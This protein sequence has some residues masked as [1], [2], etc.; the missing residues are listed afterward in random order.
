MGHVW[1]RPN[2][3]N[4]KSHPNYFKDSQRGHS[5]TLKRVKVLES[6]HPSNN[7]WSNP[8]F[9]QS[10]VHSTTQKISNQI[11]SNPIDES[12]GHTTCHNSPC[13]IFCFFGRCLSLSQ[14][15]CHNGWIWICGWIDT[16]YLHVWIP[17][18][19]ISSKLPQFQGHCQGLHTD[20][21]TMRLWYLLACVWTSCNLDSLEI[22][23]QLQLPKFLE[24][25]DD[26]FVVFRW[27]CMALSIEN[28]PQEFLPVYAWKWTF[29]PL[30]GTMLAFVR[31]GHILGAPC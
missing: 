12:L 17:S 27:H 3:F 8:S 29:K 28:V 31:A 11:N 19:E 2:D 13:H 23:L 6:I 24:I 16:S 25:H 4:L 30:D 7:Q 10:F 9:I 14:D 26:R 5:N 15:V 20:A 21:Y 1:R 18:C 22:E